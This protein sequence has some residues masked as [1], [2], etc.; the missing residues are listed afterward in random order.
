MTLTK[1]GL[2][3]FNLLAFVMIAML[4]YSLWHFG[5]RLPTFEEQSQD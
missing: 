2:S 1:I 5:Q 4:L 3:I